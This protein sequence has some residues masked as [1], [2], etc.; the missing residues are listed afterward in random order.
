[1][2]GK[3]QWLITWILL[4]LVMIRQLVEVI[5]RLM[6]S[7]QALLSNTSQWGWL[8]LVTS[9]P[10]LARIHTF[11]KLSLLKLSIVLYFFKFMQWI[12]NTTDTL[13]YTISI[14]ESSKVWL[15]WILFSTVSL[16]KWTNAVNL[17][18]LLWITVLAAINKTLVWITKIFSFEW[19]DA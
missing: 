2:S 13:C 11:E 4:S 7:P 15:L 5:V 10:Y 1:M 14:R 17:F 12:A 18:V 9:R 3:F 8:S 16:S 6:G 19:N